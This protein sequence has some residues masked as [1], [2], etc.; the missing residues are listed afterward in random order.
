MTF[1]PDCDLKQ[2]TE[3]SSHNSAF[4]AE[5]PDPNVNSSV[6]VTSRCNSNP[7]HFPGSGCGSQ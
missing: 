7:A 2:S 5:I 3:A 4:T 1:M 6:T